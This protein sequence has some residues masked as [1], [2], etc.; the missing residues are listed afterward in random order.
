M[1]LPKWLYRNPEHFKE[2]ESEKIYIVVFDKLLRRLFMPSTKII[3]CLGCNQEKYYCAK[4]LCRS[5]YDKQPNQIVKHKKYQHTY[6]I[7]NKD[8]CNKKARNWYKNHLGKAREYSWRTQGITLSYE[9][10]EALLKSYNNKCRACNHTPSEK[11]RPLVPDHC[12]ASR[13]IRRILCFECNRIYGIL[14]ENPARIKEVML[15]MPMLIK[16]ALEDHPNWP[17]DEIA[18]D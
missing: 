11:E 1:V 15:G 4:G 10:F 8:K 9:L 17:S 7:K 5:C 18:A 13:Q 16:F 14:K 12:H 6:Y 2:S 3:L